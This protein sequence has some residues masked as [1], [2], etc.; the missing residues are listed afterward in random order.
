MMLVSLFASAQR[1][2]QPPSRPAATSDS[3]TSR[4]TSGRS[5]SRSWFCGRYVSH[6][7]KFWYG[8]YPFAVCTAPSNPTY[9]PSTSPARLG[10]S[11]EW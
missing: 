4:A 10:C 1:G 3:A 8:V 2:S 5:I 7:E 9:F 6:S 11:S